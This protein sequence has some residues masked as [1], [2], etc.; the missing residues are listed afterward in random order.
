MINLKLFEQHSEYETYINSSDKILPN[1]SYCEDN[2]E[3]HYNPLVIMTVK[4]NITDTSQPTQLYAY[5]SQDINGSLMFDNVKIDNVELS[6]SDID[7]AEGK[8][9]FNTTGEHVAKYT[10]KDPTIIGIEMDMSTQQ[11]TRVGAMFATCT[12]ITEITI[13]NSVTTIGLEVFLNCSGLTSVTIPNSVTS[14]GYEAFEYSGLTSV[15]IPNRILTIDDFAF[16]GCT[17]L[18]SVTI[19]SSVTSIGS[20]AF[21]NCTNLTSVTVKAATPP[22]L[23]LTPFDNNASGRKIYVP[24]ESV[25]AY[26]AATNWSTYASD[27]EAIQ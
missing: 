23:G 1:V 14:I 7:T 15:T 2:N 25:A 9:Q 4:Y 17:G 11:I 19:P 27:I 3:V 20:G 24:A 18:T 21:D 13:P 6:I 22:T 8:Y 12:T 10:L 26:K 5:L 16:N